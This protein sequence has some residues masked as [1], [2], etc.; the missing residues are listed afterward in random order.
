MDNHN[1]FHEDILKEI[2]RHKGTFSKKD[3]KKYKVGLLL[4]Q[5]KRV[6]VFSPDCEECERLQETIKHLSDS[7]ADIQQSDKKARKNYFHAISNVSKHL[8][9]QHNLIPEGYYIELGTVYGLCF[10]ASFG[11]VFGHVAIGVG[12]G[13]PL[14]CA[15]GSAR[16]SKAKQEGK[17]I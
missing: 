17:V 2:D 9:K 7:L 6:N 13:L 4:R 8:R 14:G 1:D 15:L 3:N 11:V 5:A 16:D 10:G 12:V